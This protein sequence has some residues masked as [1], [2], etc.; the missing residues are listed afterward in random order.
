MNNSHSSPDFVMIGGQSDGKV[1]LLASTELRHIELKTELEN[2]NLYS[3]YIGPI[4]TRSPSYRH[5]ITAEMRSYVQVVADTYPQAFETLFNQW[6][7]QTKA[8]AIDGQKA[9]NRTPQ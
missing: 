4:P 8:N 3:H 1:Y 5:T 7:P 2:M 9:I 6:A